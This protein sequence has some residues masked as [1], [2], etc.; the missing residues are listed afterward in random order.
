[1][2]SFHLAILA[3]EDVTVSPALP[4]DFHVEG[5][6]RNKLPTVRMGL[7]LTEQ[8]L[9]ILGYESKLVSVEHS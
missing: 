8:Q 4:Q 6:L 3:R 2:A 9:E 1:M 7:C 5:L